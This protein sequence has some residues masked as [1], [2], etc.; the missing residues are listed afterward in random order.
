M[1]FIHMHNTF[2][3]SLP[4][5][6]LPSIVLFPVLMIIFLPFSCVCVFALNFYLSSQSLTKSMWNSLHLVLNVPIF[7]CSVKN[8]YTNFNLFI[9][10]VATLSAQLWAF[11]IFLENRTLKCL[12]LLLLLLLPFH[13]KVTHALG[14]F[15]DNICLIC[16]HFH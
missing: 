4:P 3:S 10:F 2:W 15:G 8:Q 12:W 13:L 9:H 1:S 6:P 14:L 16:Y 11:H 7:L 5:P